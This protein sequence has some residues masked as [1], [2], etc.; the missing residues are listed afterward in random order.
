MPHRNQPEPN[1]ATVASELA[2]L[3]DLLRSHRPALAAGLERR[4]R[5]LRGAPAGASAWAWLT[6]TA[7]GDVGA[8]GAAAFYSPSAR[9]TRP[10][11]G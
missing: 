3:A 2:E 6:A 10:S 8:A 5:V 7:P 9:V 11:C 4:A 1:A